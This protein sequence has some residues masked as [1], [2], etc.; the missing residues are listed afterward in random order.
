MKRIWLE[1]GDY[2]DIESLGRDHGIR[3]RLADKM[4]YAKGYKYFTDAELLKIFGYSEE[5]EGGEKA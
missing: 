2:I 4:G 5:K 3:I 1:N